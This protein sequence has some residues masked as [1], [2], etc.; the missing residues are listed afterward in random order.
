MFCHTLTLFP[1]TFYFRKVGMLLRHLTVGLLIF[2]SFWI[3]QSLFKLCQ[4]SEQLKNLFSHLLLLFLGRLFFCWLF[5]FFFFFFDLRL[6]F[7]GVSFQELIDSSLCID[8]LLASSEERVR[9][10]RNGDITYW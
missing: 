1:N 5:F 6:R 10:R 4:A 3:C 8:E 9:G 2:K 7:S